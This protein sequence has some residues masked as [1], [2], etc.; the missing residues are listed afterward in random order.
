M[1]Q[2]AGVSFGLSKGAGRSVLT[3]G[4]QPARPGDR[5]A[6]RRRRAL[7]PSMDNVPS[8]TAAVD[9]GYIS[10][11]VPLMWQN[12]ETI[13]ENGTLSMLAGAAAAAGSA[14]IPPTG[15]DER[16][17]EATAVDSRHPAW[18]KESPTPHARELCD[19]PLAAIK[20]PRRT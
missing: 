20:S 6:H 4:A 13:L 2:R 10:V 15:P 17:P 12:S 19:T 8:S 5:A 9:G 14:P 7:A 3:G 16:H 18:A 1:A 11:H